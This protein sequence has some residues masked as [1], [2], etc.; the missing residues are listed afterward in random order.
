MHSKFKATRQLLMMRPP[1][2]RRRRHINKIAVSTALR[3][4]WPPFLLLFLTLI[5]FISTHMALL[6]GF[7]FT[8][9]IPGIIFRKFFRLKSYELLVLVPIF[10]VM[11]S[12]HLIY[13]L[14]F[15]LGY[16][17]ETI[18][19]SFLI[20]TGLYV[21]LD[22]RWKDVNRFRNFLKLRSLT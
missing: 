11:V 6:T 16:S 5:S 3:K 18:L 8:F 19:A 22:T 17:R 10:S 21:V 20:L 1:P 7:V 14:S 15:L 12:T 2:Y 9:F 13:C 4:H